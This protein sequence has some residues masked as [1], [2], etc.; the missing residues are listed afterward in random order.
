MASGQNP[1]EMI[2][3]D[4]HFRDAN[5]AVIDRRCPL[6][7]VC[8]LSGAAASR[9][10]RVLFHFRATHLIGGTGHADT[11]LEGLRYYF[12]DVPKALLQLPMADALCRRRAWGWFFLVLTFVMA[13]A[14]IVGLIVSQQAIDA[15]PA[16]P[17]KKS[18]NDWLVPTIAFGGF[19]LLAVCSAFSYY[20]MP[21]PTVRLKVHNITET[22]VWLEGA[23]PEFL[24]ALD[25]QAAQLA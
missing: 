13:V 11:L 24:D 4:G 18:L 1:G 6:P 3:S 19:A 25:D 21:M 23:A 8:I 15:L 12:Q 5:V 10:V 20:I 17:Q 2:P 14:T 7:D 9:R 22:H 16:G